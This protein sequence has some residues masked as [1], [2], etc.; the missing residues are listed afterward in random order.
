MSFRVV[1][2]IHKPDSFM[3]DYGQ[4]MRQA[5]IEVDF[6]KIDCGTEDEII[7][8]AR[9]ADAIVGVGTFQPISRRVIQALP[10]CRFIMSLGIGYDKLDAKAATEHGILAANVPDYCID[11]MS[12][13]TMALMLTCTRKI[14]KLNT[15]VRQG[16]WKQEPE[17][18]I[19][20]GIWPTMS[21]LGGQTLGLIG[22][23]RIGRAVVPRAKSFGMR[24]IA[25]SPHVPDDV[26]ESLGVERVSLDRLLAESDVISL[27]TSLTPEKRHLLGIDQFK[28]MKPSAI[29]VNTARGGLVD[30]KAL[31]EALG[32]GKLGGAAL[33]VTDPEPIALDDPLLKL[34]NVIVTAHSAHASIPALLALLMRPGEELVRVFKGEW[35]VGL[36]N[37][38]AKAKYRERFARTP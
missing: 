4:M 38:D 14:V 31:Y 23:G 28:K 1:Q 26:L 17:P 16:G 3:P 34:E 27:H 37:P 11:E 13:H 22:L 8:A 19:Q 24:V 30:Q 21:R 2:I 36:I 9:D 15:F 29:L 20:R 10:R 25:Y 12:D 6:E 7:A 5:G 33:D 35:P 18:G 32:A